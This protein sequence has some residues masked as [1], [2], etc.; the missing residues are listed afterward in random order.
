[1]RPPSL[2]LTCLSIALLGLTTAQAAAPDLAVAYPPP[3]TSVPYDHVIF[4]G[5]VS[6]GATLSVN[7]RALNVGPDGLFMEWLPLAP[8][9]NALKL[10]STLGNQRRAA[11]FNVTSNLPKALP[12]RPTTIKAETLTPAQ[13]INLYTRLPAEG[14]TLTVRFQGSPGGRAQV[15]VKGLGQFAL[16][17]QAAST[18]PP[19]AAGWYQTT[20]TLPETAALTAAPIKVSLTGKDGTTV[21]ATA[22][23]TLT[24]APASAARVAEI[25]AAEVGVGVNPSPTAWTTGEKPTDRL[26]P[27]LGQRLKVLGD[28]GDQF[29]VQGPSGLATAFKATLKLLP[30]GT[31]P[32]AAGVGL[33]TWQ[34]APNEWQLHLPISQRTPFTLEDAP[35]SAGK[36][37]SLRL[38]IADAA[39][40]AGSLAANQRT[41]ILT[42][43]PQ[44]AALK[45]DISLPQVQNWGYFAVYGSGELVLHLRKA[46][47]LDPQQPLRGRLIVIDPGHG[48]SELGG[49]GS[50]GQPEK[51]IVLPIAL[52]VAAL[53]RAQGAD[54]RLTRSQD[55]RVPLYDRPLLAEHLG[56][57]LLISLHANA[58][59]D[60]VDPRARRGLEVHTFHPQTWGLAEET[61]RQPAALGSSASGHGPRAADLAGP[62]PER[63]GAGPAHLAAQRT[64]RAGL[65]DP[66]G[67][68]A[69]ADE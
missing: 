58:L 50:L 2:P 42:W 64:D 1:M 67:R 8:G 45:L 12:A 32:P 3:N 4:E 68:P 29:L 35:P 33:P 66:G 49:A 19:Q 38:L 26:F 20:L 40:P 57:D 55:T 6:P 11:T 27:K 41:P 9:K 7:G 54:V 24:S 51:T 25:T 30:I 15:T 14:R 53:L 31:P 16:T 10:L 56:A 36:G 62:A 48:G 63:P 61:D 37:A 34:D 47:A 59:P 21:I 65:P 13:P 23:G 60:G 28:L 46:P 43:E 39:R 18:R 5:H 52:R 22:P 69:A 44:S 17:E